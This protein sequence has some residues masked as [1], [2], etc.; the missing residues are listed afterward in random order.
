MR[1]YLALS[2][3]FT[4]FFFGLT[5][6]DDWEDDSWHPGNGS[7]GGGEPGDGEVMLLKEQNISMDGLLTNY[8]YTYNADDRIAEIVITQNGTLS[9]NTVYTYTGSNQIK[10]VAKGYMNGEVV[11]TATAVAIIEGNH[12]YVTTTTEYPGMPP[13]VMENDV[14][15]EAPCGA[16]E[17]IITIN[18]DGTPMVTTLTYEYTDPNCSYKEFSDGAHVTTVTNDAMNAPVLDPLV[19]QLG[20]VRHNPLKIQDL[21]ESSIETIQY[22]YNENGYPTFAEHVTVQTGVPDQEWTEEFIYY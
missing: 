5:S 6:C 2:L 10:A 20:V 9:S 8:A 18:M 1:K 15:F 17:N 7:G 12:Q 13:I 16:L 4:V 11:M 22:T 3:V 19:T 14:T 21:S